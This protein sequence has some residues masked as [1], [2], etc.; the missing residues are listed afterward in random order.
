MLDRILA[1]RP[2]QRT[3][4]LDNLPACLTKDYLIAHIRMEQRLGRTFPM[5]F[6]HRVEQPDLNRIC[7]AYDYPKEHPELWESSPR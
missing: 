6:G 4:P 5:S 1:G 7:D 3:T 2:A